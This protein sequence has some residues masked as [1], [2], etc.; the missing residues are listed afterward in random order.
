M[1]C[2]LLDVRTRTTV[3]ENPAIVALGDFILSNNIVSRILAMV[4]ERREV[5][6]V[7]VE[8]L[9]P[10]GQEVVVKDSARYV[11]DQER[12]SFWAVCL[13]A[14][15]FGEI[16]LGYKPAEGDGAIVT[17]PRDKAAVRTW[18]HSDRLILMGPSAVRARAED[19]DFASSCMHVQAQERS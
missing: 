8:L 11:H 10:E 2:E 5:E 7:L 17:N 1:C 3:Q 4:A 14:Q 19:A 15:E 12:L 18:S 16:L 13:R 9:G 6:S